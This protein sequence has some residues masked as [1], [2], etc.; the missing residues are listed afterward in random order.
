M[1]DEVIIKTKHGFQET[2]VTTIKTF[3]IPGD[4]DISDNQMCFRVSEYTPFEFGLTIFKDTP[5]GITLSKMIADKKDL[6]LIKLKVLKWYLQKASPRLLVSKI[7]DIQRVSFEEGQKNKANEIKKA[8][9][10][11]QWY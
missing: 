5:E 2:G 7:K 1:W 11:E 8:L 6:E 9:G 10:V 4:H 3:S